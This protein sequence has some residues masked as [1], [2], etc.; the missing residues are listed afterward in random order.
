MTWPGV[1][2]LSWVLLALDHGLRGLLMIGDAGPRPSFI[3]ALV[4][5]IGLAAPA[6]TAL[7]TSLLLGVVVDLLDQVPTM[8]GELRTVLGPHALGYLAAMQFIL[9]MRPLINKR[10]PLSFGFLGLVGTLISGVVVVILFTL[11]TI[12]N[13]AVVWHAK[14][15]LLVMLG[16]AVYTGL[17]AT[18]LSLALIPMS[19][20]L[21]LQQQGQQ[22]RFAKR[23]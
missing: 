15:E 3:F 5:A 1:L 23:A 13:D 16:S 8:A 10:N 9:T 20:F 19:G 6:P 2:V 22:R 17:L 12:Y 11:R 14:H 4:V 7:W 18:L 21:G